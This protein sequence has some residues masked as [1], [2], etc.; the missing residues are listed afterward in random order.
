MII[1]NKDELLDNEKNDDENSI[2][3]DNNDSDLVWEEI[4]TEHLIQDEWIDFRR[5][6]FRFPDGSEFEPYYSYSRRNYVV[7]VAT[8]EEGNYICVRQYRYGIKE[9]TTEFPAGGIEVSDNDDITSREEGNDSDETTSHKD[10]TN[11]VEYNLSS[12]YKV[13]EDVALEA[14]VRELQEETG[15]VSDEWRHLIT[16][17]SN[18]TIADNYAYIFEAKN[19]RKVSGLMLDDTEFLNVRKYSAAELE[20]MV[21]ENKFQQAIHIMAWLY[22]KNL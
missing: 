3:T 8:D 13:S 19:C 5:S 2:D 11:Q 6:A 7:I 1:N 21:K 20:K 9:V 22:S 15:Y 10:V 12:N 18:A 4:K 17:A 14:A 16:V